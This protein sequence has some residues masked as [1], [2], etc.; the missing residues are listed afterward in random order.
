MYSFHIDNDEYWLETPSLTTNVQF[1]P[2]GSMFHEKVPNRAG[3]RLE[4][5]VFVSFVEDKYRK[6]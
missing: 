4:V 2:V 5:A 6:K 1:P 3:E